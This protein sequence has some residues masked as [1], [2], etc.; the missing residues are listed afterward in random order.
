MLNTYKESVNSHSFK[1]INVCE[2]HRTQK[3]DHANVFPGDF[4]S[5]YLS[6]LV[7]T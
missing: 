3:F 7:G 4:E 6:E 5:D 1:N 2:I